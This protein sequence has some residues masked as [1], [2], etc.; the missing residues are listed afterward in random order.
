MRRGMALGQHLSSSMTAALLAPCQV[1]E[2][3]D[4]ATERKITQ[5]FLR[6]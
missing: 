6:N 2:Q 4:N 5:L 1:L 3:E